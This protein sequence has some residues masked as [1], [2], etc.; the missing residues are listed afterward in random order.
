MTIKACHQPI[1]SLYSYD[2]IIIIIIII[3]NNVFFFFFFFFFLFIYL[4]FFFFF[5]CGG[6]GWGSGL[7]NWTIR[8][9]LVTGD[10]R[11]S[12][13]DVLSTDQKIPLLRRNVS[14]VV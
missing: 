6:G 2:V 10:L 13:T 12:R 1:T 3:I 5:F 11:Q 8:K 4:F 7:S 14:F 9:Y